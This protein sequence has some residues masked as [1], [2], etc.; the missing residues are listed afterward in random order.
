MDKVFDCIDFLIVVFIAY[1]LFEPLGEY[2]GAISRYI[3]TRGSLTPA[4]IPEYVGIPSS[5]MIMLEI[6]SFD[7]WVMN[8]ALFRMLI[9][10]WVGL[11]Y[12][13]RYFGSNTL[14]GIH[15]FITCFFTFIELIRAFYYIIVL[16]LCSSFAICYVPRIALST[17]WST[18]F[19]IIFS[20]SILTL[21]VYLLLIF[22][23]AIVIWR[24]RKNKTLDVDDI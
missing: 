1:F 19:L 5:Q 3:F 22:F 13:F 8:F 16:L 12:V 21:V 11:L 23:T 24:N 10:V 14:M 7:Y 6:Y 15:L 4:M 20:L 17:T 2:Y 9:P 18:E